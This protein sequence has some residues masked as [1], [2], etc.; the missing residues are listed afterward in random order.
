MQAGVGCWLHSNAVLSR[1]PDCV[2]VVMSV[3]WDAY[4]KRVWGKVRYAM[5]FSLISLYAQRLLSVR[6]Q[7][8]LSHVT[9]R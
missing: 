7:A 3:C 5:R 1:L 6:P 8:T 9:A 2:A 4:S